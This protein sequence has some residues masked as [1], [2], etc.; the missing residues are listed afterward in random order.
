MSPVTGKLE[1]CTGNCKYGNVAHVQE[2]RTLSQITRAGK[3]KET[4]RMQDFVK[5]QLQ[6]IASEN[7]L[8]KDQAYRETRIAVND[9][10]FSEIDFN[11]YTR[12]AYIAS[13]V[14]DYNYSPATMFS[15]A[16][17]ASGNMSFETVRPLNAI[18]SLNKQLDYIATDGANDP[19]A[20]MSNRS[21]TVK[22]YQGQRRRE[23][24]TVNF[25]ADIQGAYNER[26]ALGKVAYN[27]KAEI[28]EAEKTA[29]TQ[30]NYDP[31][32]TAVDAVREKYKDK[33]KG[34]SDSTA[35]AASMFKQSLQE[36]ALAEER[37]ANPNEGMGHKAS[38]SD[39]TYLN[40]K[41]NVETWYAK[42]TVW[43]A[44]ATY[45]EAIIGTIDQGI[46]DAKV[47]LPS[48]S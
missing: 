26:I 8:K 7:K 37:I 47:S 33:L 23:G 39:I 43:R 20:Y 29:R 21:V 40:T 31:Y 25:N 46:S 1:R 12:G 44:R 28:G 16:I 18:I 42:A 48:G 4:K 41:K 13:D 32:N 9:R 30:V 17:D 10:Y 38:F 15:S 36:L 19:D 14:G 35:Y 45:Y 22:T 27:L 5:D 3:A 6:T 24:R 34:S 11:P 2:S